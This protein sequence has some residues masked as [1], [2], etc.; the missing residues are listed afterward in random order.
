MVH[1]INVIFAVLILLLMSAAAY[2]MPVIDQNQPNDP[3]YM[4][5]FSQIDLAQSFQQAHD[6]ISG[7]GIFLY[8]SVLGTDS[9]TISLWDAL[10]N[11]AGNMLTAGTNTGTS[12]N[13]VDVFWDPF[14]VTPDT[15]LFLVFTS[16]LNTLGISGDT[17]NPYLRGQVYA[18]PGFS[19]YPSYDYTFR[20]YYDDEMSQ[21]VPEPATMLLL[22][23]G[24]A[25]LFGLRRKL[26]KR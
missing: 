17:S 15:T 21:P 11:E 6:N 9:I 12:G 23:S 1:R 5:H 22:G 8:P 25:G 4:A 20:T 19:S 26:R 14:S 2:A 18:N 16:E 24:L 13:W 3:N 10:P 7:A